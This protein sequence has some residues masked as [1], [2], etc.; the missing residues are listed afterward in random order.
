MNRAF[1]GGFR[2]RGEKKRQQNGR[3]RALPP[4]KTP[5]A[6]NPKDAQK[7]RRLRRQKRFFQVVMRSRMLNLART[8]A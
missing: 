5:Q 6:K 4:K 2:P 8:K 3:S 7:K 1:I